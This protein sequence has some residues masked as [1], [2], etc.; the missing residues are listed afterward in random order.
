LNLRHDQKHNP[1]Q[2]VETDGRRHH[3]S[4]HNANFIIINAGVA[5][6]SDQKHNPT[7]RIRIISSVHAVRLAGA[8]GMVCIEDNANLSACGPGLAF[9][10]QR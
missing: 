10:Q 1:T 8:A 2:P 9:D 6:L 7:P 5:V 4:G 3:R